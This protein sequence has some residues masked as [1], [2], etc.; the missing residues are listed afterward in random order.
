M[1]PQKKGIPNE[2]HLIVLSIKNFSCCDS[3]PSDTNKYPYKWA[4]M[5]KQKKQFKI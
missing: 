4:K 3:E 5:T 1:N 2:F